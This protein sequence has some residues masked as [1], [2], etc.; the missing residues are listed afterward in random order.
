[1]GTQRSLSLPPP[2]PSFYPAPRYLLVPSAHP[3]P[4]PRFIASF[5]TPKSSE[6]PTMFKRGG[7]YYV[8]AGTGCCACIGGSSIYVLRADTVDG[9][10][11]FLG[12]VGSIPG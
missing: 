11:V 3:L 2:R 12:D 6:G 7:K 8:T 9:P 4:C 5:S 1:M 10:Y